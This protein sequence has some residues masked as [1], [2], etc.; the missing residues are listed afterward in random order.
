M[1]LFIDCEWNDYKG[2]LISIALCA[3][4]GD[5]FYE[6]LECKN[7]SDWIAKNVIPVLQKQAIEYS[8][9]QEKLADFLNQYSECHIVADWPEDI[10]HFCNLLIVGA[11]ERLNT[12]DLSFSVVR[13]NAGSDIP[14]NALA[15]A[16]GLM[17]IAK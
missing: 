6:V 12:V 2:D 13:L 5:E 4:N 17:A 8:D 11:G 15:D 7:P 1:K 16:R 14:H 9:L 3:E 10:A